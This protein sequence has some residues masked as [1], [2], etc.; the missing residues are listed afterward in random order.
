MLFMQWPAYIHASRFSGY[1]AH[2]T[3]GKVR[4]QI[5]F[6]DRDERIYALRRVQGDISTPISGK[7]FPARRVKT[8][9]QKPGYVLAVFFRHQVFGANNPSSVYNNPVIVAVDALPPDAV[10]PFLGAQ[11]GVRPHIRLENKAVAEDSGISFV[12]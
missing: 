8:F 1:P 6:H 10:G 7:R 3:L 11:K 5:F 4:G 9:S 12:A 2:Q